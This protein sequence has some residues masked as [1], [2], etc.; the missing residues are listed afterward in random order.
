MRESAIQ[1]QIEEYLTY[2]E[3]VGRLV[4]Q[5]NNSGAVKIRHAKGDS[6]VR[7]GKRG[8]PDFLIWRT[9]PWPDAP[10]IIW[11]GRGRLDTLFVEVKNEKGKQ[12]EG[13]KEFQKRVEDLGGTYLIVHSLDELRSA[14]Q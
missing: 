11:G 13:Q 2:Q 12:S 10:G 9:V 4:F 3:N 8:A 6:F 5:K 14:L 1:K 7:F